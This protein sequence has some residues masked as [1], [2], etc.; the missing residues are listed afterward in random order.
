MTI[1]TRRL[2]LFGLV[3]AVL[4]A[5]LAAYFF[6]GDGRARESRKAGPSKAGAARAVLVGTVTVQPRTLEV[7]EEVVG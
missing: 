2:A 3:V 4:G 7:Y 6:A 5:A 1:A